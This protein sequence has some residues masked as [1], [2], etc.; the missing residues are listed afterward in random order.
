[1]GNNKIAPNIN[2]IYLKHFMDIFLGLIQKCFKIKLMVY[3]YLIPR[4][5]FNK[6][7][8][9]ANI[10]YLSKF[11]IVFCINLLCKDANNKL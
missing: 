2:D 3:L 5:S 8:C 4:Q 6:I 7:H 9:T 11:L 10:R 1:M